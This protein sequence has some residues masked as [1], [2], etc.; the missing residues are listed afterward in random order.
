MGVPL[1]GVT[2]GH[3]DK[4]H[5]NK[6]HKKQEGGQ[7]KVHA[8]VENLQGV[9]S[10]PYNHHVDNVER[11][12]ITEPCNPLGRQMGSL[13]RSA[14]SPGQLAVTSSPPGPRWLLLKR[15]VIK[16]TRGRL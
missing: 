8:R 9:D 7:P 3:K 13:E 4:D 2:Q 12:K 1:V 5:H 10:K 15:V 16:T 6:G 14:M 11:G